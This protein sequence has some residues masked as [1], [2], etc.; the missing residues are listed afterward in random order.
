MQKHTI[1]RLFDFPYYQLANSP[2]KNCFVYKNNHTWLSISTKEY[3]SKANQISRALLNLGVQPTH[4][5]A[6][7]TN[8]NNAK[9]HML[10][11][12][13]LQ[14]GA[15][16]VPLYP[17]FS[18]KDYQYILNHCDAKICFVSDSELYQKVKA[19]IKHTQ[20]EKIF[21]FE[22]IN[23]DYGWSSFLSLGKEKELQ[24]KV[25]EL[26][27]NVTP[28]NLATIIYTSGTTG[29][30]KGVM[31]S[32]KNISDNIFAVA[33]KINLGQ[34]NKKKRVISYLPICHIFER[35]SSYY[36]QQMGF[37]IYFAESIDKIG[38]N[39]KEVKPHFMAVVP[40]LLEKVYDKIVDKGSNLKGVKKQL[41]F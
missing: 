9:W 40:R 24:T 7:I 34:D 21:S 12:G 4:K 22:D 3:L 26:K 28:N 11:I 5:I 30:P 19:V 29:T 27:N 20:I 8:N 23:T 1:T 13:T 16:N 17:T 39:L 10:D 38:D 31:L 2:Q 14:I 32:H 6:V 18:E 36:C 41:F 33:K 37:E 15:V 25:T 35:A